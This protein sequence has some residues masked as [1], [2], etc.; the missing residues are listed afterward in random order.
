MPDYETY[1]EEEEEEPE[2]WVFD[3]DECDDYELEG[4]LINAELNLVIAHAFG[5]IDQ[6]DDEN[7]VV[8]LPDHIKESIAQLIARSIRHEQYS[9]PLKAVK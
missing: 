4:C 5:M 7:L 1:E 3:P 9:E 2:F 8:I 6:V